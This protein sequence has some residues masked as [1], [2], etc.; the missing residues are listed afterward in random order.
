[1]RRLIGFEFLAPPALPCCHSLTFPAAFCYFLARIEMAQEVWRKAHPTC[2]CGRG[3]GPRASAA[4]P[5]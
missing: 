4:E 3:C 2:H 5:T 1:M